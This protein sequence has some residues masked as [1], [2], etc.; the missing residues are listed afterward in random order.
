M[1]RLRSSV[2]GLVE[3]I[4]AD[5]PA[6]AAPTRADWQADLLRLFGNELLIGELDLTPQTP[7]DYHSADLEQLAAELEREY[8]LAASR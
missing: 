5:L 6:L 3:I 8:L 4:P 2:I 7:D 1:S